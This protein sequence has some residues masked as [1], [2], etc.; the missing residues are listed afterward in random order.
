MELFRES[1]ETRVN[2]LFVNTELEELLKESAISVGVSIGF[3]CVFHHSVAL[4]LRWLRYSNTFLVL[5]LKHFPKLLIYSALDEGII[6]QRD[7]SILIRLLLISS[8]P[9]ESLLGTSTFK[10]VSDVLV[11]HIGEM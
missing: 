9:L 11:K 2:L 3:V 7:F 1:V 8:L 4:T 5:L 6:S 10:H